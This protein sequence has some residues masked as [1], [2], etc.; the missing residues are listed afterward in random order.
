MSYYML[1]L[2]IILLLGVSS[3]Y[4]GAD[5]TK[6]CRDQDLRQDFATGLC[7]T[8]WGCGVCD[9]LIKTTTREFS[10]FASGANTTTSEHWINRTRLVNMEGIEKEIGK[11][12][13]YLE[14]ADELIEQHDFEEMQAAMM[15]SDKILARIG[16]VI[17][18]LEEQK[19][20]QGETA[21][22]VRQWK[23]ETKGKYTNLL[24]EREKISKVL[25]AQ[26]KERELDQLRAKQE[27]EKRLAHDKHETERQFWQEKSKAELE[28]TEK[29]LELERAV[30]ATHAKLPKLKI[31]PFNGTA[32]DWVRFE[33]MFLTQVD[34]KPITDEE[35]FGYL[36]EM[37]TGKVRDKISNIK[38]G[39]IGYKTAWDRLKTEYG[40]TKVVIHT[41]MESII[42]LQP[43]KGTNYEKVQEFYDKLSKNY[44]AL[45]TLGQAD[46]LKGLVITTLNKLPHVKPDL[47]RVDES[48]EEWDMGA[49]IENL[50]KWLRRNKPAEAAGGGS[51]PKKLREKHW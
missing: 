1:S 8:K 50:Q 34:A 30:K 26:T 16:D 2:T 4:R 43:V 42:N 7:E 41:H 38:P 9:I 36:L 12:R 48:W 5:G 19:I 3:F 22:N 40:Q 51:D 45:N 49:L 46:M 28:L 25:D 35:K 10:D 47:V 24:L 18:K 21:R 13:Y 14:P 32:S 17:M 33:N 11:L 37:V 29:K 20:D 27:F 39:S 6:W 44:D 15:Q 31:T 23:K